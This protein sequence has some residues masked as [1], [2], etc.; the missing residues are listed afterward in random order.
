MA[1]FPTCISKVD[2]LDNTERSALARV[3]VDAAATVG[4]S[5]ESSVEIAVKPSLSGNF[6]FGKTKLSVVTNNPEGYSLYLQTVSGDPSLKKAQATAGPEQKITSI[7]QPTIGTNFTGNTWGYTLSQDELSP[8]ST[9]LPIPTT[10]TT[11]L[12]QTKRATGQVQAD[13][14]VI[15]QPDIYHLGFGAH[16][17]ASLEA[18]E[19]TNEVVAS[20]IA[21]PTKI[22]T[23]SELV[24]MQDMTPEICANTAVPDSPTG[25]HVEKQL[26]DLRDGK[27]YFVSKLRDGNCWMTQNLAFD[28]V[29]G[30]TLTSADTD[31][32]ENWTIPSSTEPNLSHNI[33][34]YHNQH[35]AVVSWSQGNVIAKVP[36]GNRVCPTMPGSADGFNSVNAE[37]DQTL[38][39]NCPSEY[40]DV[41]TL[42]PS[43]HAIA[44]ETSSIIDGQYDPHYLIGNFYTWP[45]ATAGSGAATDAQNLANG[46][47]GFTDVQKLVDAKNSICP[48]GWKLPTA[49]SYIDK[50]TEPI[51]AA[52]P[53]DREDS[54]YALIHA[55]GYPET[56]S[57]TNWV[58]NEGFPY[59][60]L[61][62]GE[63]TRVDLKP[64]YF[65]RSGHIE[66]YYN[67]LRFAGMV[68]FYHSSTA[69]PNSTGL[70]GHLQF[71]LSD[72][73]INPGV[74]S[75]RSDGSAVRCFAR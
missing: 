63:R 28:L 11:P 44:T 64:V 54:F 13:G 74:H 50:S 8:S 4:L 19:Y 69:Y 5:L 70:A 2:A 46:N 58:A 56:G 1:L 20:V 42:S 3:T 37:T 7:T 25:E 27:K 72:S 75:G 14:S 18:G 71:G 10:S 45:A 41:S 39:E 36:I 73:T 40:A 12:V 61:I 51:A 67:A 33:S 65:V 38:A 62:G 6:N 32:D 66:T 22:T 48:K 34:N 31:V 53:F 24:F 57:N 52:W 43:N 15:D 68:G 9:F 59:T 47:A 16:V 26:Y 23:L 30:R 35:T 55:Y 21:N 49:G 17:G 60:T 29:A